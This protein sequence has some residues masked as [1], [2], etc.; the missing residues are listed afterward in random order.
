MNPVIIISGGNRDNNQIKEYINNYSPFIIAVDSGAKSCIDINIRPDVALGDFDSID[1]KY[2]SYLPKWEK[3]GTK[4]IK[5][6]PIKDDTDTEFALN[7]AIKNTTGDIFLFG[8]T[9]SRLDHTI[10][11]ANLLFLGLKPNRR[12]ELID[13]N[14]KIYLKNSSFEIEKN[15]QYGDFISLFPFNGIVEGLTLKGFFYTLNNHRLDGLS[16]LCVSNEITEEVAYITFDS[17][18]LLVIESRD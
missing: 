12:I 11:N 15:K 14:N 5:L 7:Y 3:F 10:S 1:T 18:T 2:L 16:S 9:G 6:N 8:A 13:K 4:I 17:G